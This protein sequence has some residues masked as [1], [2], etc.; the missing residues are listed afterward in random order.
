MFTVVVIENNKCINQLCNVSKHELPIAVDM[1][2]RD[3]TH[4]IIIV[5]NKSG[6]VVQT[7]CK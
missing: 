2:R 3:Y 6:T 1:F 5:E 4:A 7:Y